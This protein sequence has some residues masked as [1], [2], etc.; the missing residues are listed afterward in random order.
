MTKSDHANRQKRW[1]VVRNGCQKWKELDKISN[2]IN[3]KPLVALFS[4]R[5]Y[6]R[7][8]VRKILKD[9]HGWVARQPYK[10]FKFSLF[11]TTLLHEILATR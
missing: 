8:K 7:L 2:F 4:V 9:L 5:F 6:E 10:S 3:F 1:Y 11:L